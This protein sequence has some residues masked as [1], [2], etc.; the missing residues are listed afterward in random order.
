MNEWMDG[1]TLTVFSLAV[2]LF[3]YEMWVLRREDVY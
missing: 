2:E 3:L 1:G